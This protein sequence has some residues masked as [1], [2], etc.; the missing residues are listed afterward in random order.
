MH[1]AFSFGDHRGVPES[2]P[3]DLDQYKE[4]LCDFRSSATIDG[5]VFVSLR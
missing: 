3:Y 4:D 2:S 1:W 5:S